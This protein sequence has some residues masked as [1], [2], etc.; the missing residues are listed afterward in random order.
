MGTATG[1]DKKEYMPRFEQYYFQSRAYE[2]NILTAPLDDFF[3]AVASCDIRFCA[4]G[5]LRYVNGKI[6]V[7]V[8]KI[9]YYIK[10]GYDFV[11]NRPLGFWSLKNKDV[12]RKGIRYIDDGSYNNYRKDSNMGGAIYRYS[13][14][15]P[16]E[17][18]KFPVLTLD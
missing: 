14:I 10:D 2:E 16:I 6:I 9:G 11:G 17:N 1:N 7:H 8:D 15:V 18:H 12:A 3:G 13:E 4:I 5:E